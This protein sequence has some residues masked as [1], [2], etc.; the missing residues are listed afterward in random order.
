[1]KKFTLDIQPDEDYLLAGIQTSL[2]N[3]RLAWSIN[4]RMSLHLKRADDI[5]FYNREQI[6]AAF[7]YFEYYDELNRI[8]YQ[9]VGNGDESHF[10]LPELRHID[11]LMVIKGATE[12]FHYDRFIQST[13]TID[14]IQFVIALETDQLKSRHN[15]ILPDIIPAL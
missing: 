13:K 1:L 11:Y 10:L 14:G 9:L 3:Y 7:P 5:C 15:L 12:H 4:Q 8:A 6:V 2:A